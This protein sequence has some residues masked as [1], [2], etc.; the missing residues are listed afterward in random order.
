M[1]FS[2]GMFVAAAYALGCANAGYYLL[3]WRD[4]RDIRAL[5]S[6]NAGA[7][8]VGRVLGRKAFLIV[9]AL[10]AA[11]GVLAVGAAATWAY[12]MSPLCALAAVAGHVWP[13]QLGG[14]GGKGVA[15]ALGGLAVLAP[16]LL[17]LLAGAFLLGWLLWRRAVGA[18]IA[19]F[20]VAVPMAAL[21]STPPVAATC[22]ALSAL[23]TY[24]HLR[25]PRSISARHPP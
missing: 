21:V 9:F 23:L 5:G 13:V 16:L 20:W 14:R 6:G 24:T 7:K 3:R 15:T 18:G 10:D 12:A 19:A 11:K 1:T 8:N 2:D 4:G 17:A 25:S 22:L